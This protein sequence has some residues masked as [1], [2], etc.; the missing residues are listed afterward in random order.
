[1]KRIA[2]F[3]LI[4]LFASGCTLLAEKP[5]VTVKNIGINS[6][7][8]GGVDLDLVLAV[9]NPNPFSITMTRYKYNLLIQGTPFVNGGEQRTVEFAGRGS[10]DLHLPVRVPI[11]S[12]LEI[13]KQK[14]DPD[15]IPYDLNA[16]IEVKSTLLSKVFPVKSAGTVALPKEYRPAYYLNEIKSLFNGGGRGAKER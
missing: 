8:A 16:E 2:W 3:C 12:L 1:M 5:V 11:K 14:P 6:L 4:L 10:T 7:D 15:K 9:D 13:L